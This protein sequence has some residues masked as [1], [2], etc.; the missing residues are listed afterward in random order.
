M[1]STS[2]QLQ[3]YLALIDYGLKARRM[4]GMPIAS[5]GGHRGREQQAIEGLR[6]LNRWPDRAG[7][8]VGGIGQAAGQTAPLLKELAELA[9]ELK[10]VRGRGKQN[11]N[12]I[13][14]AKKVSKQTPAVA[15]GERE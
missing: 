6:A 3:R 2:Q 1:T 10:K 12:S 15:V 13:N 11:R 8:V 9:S 14:G 4:L 7:S 5:A